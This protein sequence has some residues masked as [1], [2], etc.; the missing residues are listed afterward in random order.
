MADDPFSYDPEKTV[1]RPT[2]GRRTEIKPLPKSVPRSAPPPLPEEGVAIGLPSV[3]VNPIVAAA[4]PLL[5]MAIRLRGSAT[6]PDVE[7]LREQV[8]AELKRFEQKMRAS[9]IQA[10]ALRNAHYALCATIDDIVINTPWG[11]QS[12]WAQERLTSV[13]HKEMIHGDRFFEI[14]RQLRDGGSGE[15]DVL[16]LVYLCIS[17]GFEGP[18]RGNTSELARVREDLYRTISGRRGE[19]EREL[20]P[21][22]QGI[23]AAHKPLTSKIPIWV[24]AL[25]CAAVLMVIYIGFVFMLGNASNPAFAEV[26]SLPP[27]RDFHPAIKGGTALPALVNHT[28]RLREILA[29]EIA[30]NLV[31]VD[32]DPRTITISIHG[33]AAFAVGS[34]DLEDQYRRLLERIGT[35]IDTEPGQVTVSGHTDSIPIRTAQFPSNYE[36]SLARAEAARDVIRTR[37]KDPARVVSEG[38]SDAEPIAPNDTPEGRDLNRRIEIGL[39]KP[40]AR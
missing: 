9:G 1:I 11:H 8:I 19:F 5:A 28:P 20:S 35:A 40:L 15:D 23:Q 39:I 30:Q 6:Q 21:H 10:E 34:A 27:G 36:L 14:L 4:G 7:R 3:G 32:E 16:E 38:H 29:P 22:W 12:S 26:A 17:L 2:P 31:K 18:L 37:L 25:G 24:F 33:S 13:I